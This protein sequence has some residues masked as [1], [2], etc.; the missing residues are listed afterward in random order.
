MI[1]S[2]I[3]CPNVKSLGVLHWCS[4]SV[5]RIESFPQCRGSVGSW[6][7]ESKTRFQQMGTPGAGAAGPMFC[8][9]F[10]YVQPH[11]LWAFCAVRHHHVT[12][13]LGIYEANLR[14]WV[15]KH[16]FNRWKHKI[17]KIPR[18]KTDRQAKPTEKTVGAWND[19]A[20]LG[21]ST[22]PPGLLPTRAAAACVSHLPKRGVTTWNRHSINGAKKNIC[23]HACQCWFCMI[24]YVYKY[25][26]Y[27]V[28]IY[29]YVLWYLCILCYMIWYIYIHIHSTYVVWFW[30]DWKNRSIGTEFT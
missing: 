24:L 6:C 14:I 9:S 27:I 30:S 25:S 11:L 16:N 4:L 3:L 5:Y 18:T 1:Q 22:K 26:T 8:G 12:T 23:V 28:Y 7:L 29:I 17:S 10:C 13:S 21:I 20:D 19:T 2:L 15:S